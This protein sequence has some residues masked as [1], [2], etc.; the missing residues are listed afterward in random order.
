M[1]SSPDTLSHL[2]T[3]AP[4]LDSKKQQTCILAEA[5]ARRHKL[6]AEEQRMRAS[7][8]QRMD[9]YLQSHEAACLLQCEC[10]A[11]LVLGQSLR[12]EPGY[13]IQQIS[14]PAGEIAMEAA[15]IHSHRHR[16][17]DNQEVAAGS[18]QKLQCTR[19]RLILGIS[20]YHRQHHGM[21]TGPAGRAPRWA[22]GADGTDASPTCGIALW[23]S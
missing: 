3:G 17:R 20:G 4:D 14:G 7:A 2:Q 23:V 18:S 16:W 6:A 12:E 19:E 10:R 1:S 15:G 13:K 21:S 8:L 11:D 22:R 9:H 5:G